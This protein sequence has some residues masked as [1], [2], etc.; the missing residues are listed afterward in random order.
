MLATDD[1]G[2][3]SLPSTSVK[4]QARVSRG[5]AAGTGLKG[6][7]MTENRFTRW[8]I[9]AGPLFAVLF[10]IAAFLLAGDTP[11][12]KASAAE[13][14]RYFDAHHD[15]G[16]TSVFL[17]PLGAALLLLF[18]AAMRGRARRQDDGD[19]TAA[20]MLGGAVLWASA[21]LFGSVLELTLLSASDH[22]QASVAQSANVLSATSWIPMIGGIAIFMI[23]SGLLVLTS[24][25]LPNWLGWIALVVGVVSLAGP[26][27]F[28][29]FV[30]APIWIL[31]AG[32]LLAMR[33]DESAVAPD[34]TPD[35][36][37][38]R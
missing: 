37:P 22:D 18:A 16:L 36:V 35:P 28:A 4:L 5:T 26:G 19:I 31:V 24:R 6:V 13:V 23:G 12:E 3:A 27:G 10:L 14:M 17:S 20:V 32:I 1:S 11:G 9:W 15:R 34:K 25:V 7:L 8:L 2:V 38:N 33:R 30:V 21:I 29:G